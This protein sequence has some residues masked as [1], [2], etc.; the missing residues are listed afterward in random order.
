MSLAQ[1]QF[2]THDSFFSPPVPILPGAPTVGN[3][4]VAWWS[5]NAGSTLNT[6]DWTLIASAG[7]A[8]GG[9][10]I[11]YCMYR[12][13]QS[14]DGAT[15]PALSNGGNIYRVLAVEIS[16]VTGT[17]A[18]DFDQYAAEITYPPT[19]FNTSSANELVYFAFW[20]GDGGFSYTPGSGWT[21][22]YFDSHARIL[23]WEVIS[24]SGSSAADIGTWSATIGAML[25][26]AFKE[27]GGGDATGSGTLD[28][29]D[30]SAPT[31]VYV[32]NVEGSGDIA[33]ITFSVPTAI[34]PHGV[35]ATGSL[36]TFLVTGPT[37]TVE[38]LTQ[39]GLQVLAYGPSDTRLTQLGAS[40]LAAP[41]ANARVT[42][43]GLL[44][45]AKGG[46]AP[47]K[48]DPLVLHDAGRNQT[49]YQRMV[50]MYFEPTPQGPTTSAR[51]QRPGLY[52]VANRGG[53]PVQCT[54]LWNDFRITVSGGAVWRDSINIGNI[55]VVKG[56]VRFAFSEEEAVIVAGGLAYFVTTSKVTQ[57]TDPDMPTNLVDVVLLAGRFIYIQGTSGQFAY[58]QVGD[59]QNIDG[60]SFATVEENSGQTNVGAMVLVGSIVFFTERAMEFWYAADDPDNPFQRSPGRSTD[61]GLAAIRTLVR[62]DNAI[63]F[64]GENRIIYRAG[65]AVPQR[66]SDF[67]VEDK[68]R[69]VTQ[70]D[71][72]NCFAFEVIY[73]GHTFYVISLPGQGTWACDISQSNA[74]AEWR[75]H[76]HPLFRVSCSD[77]GVYGDL[78]SGQLMGMDGGLYTDPDEDPIERVVSSYLP[79]K[80][81]NTRNFNVGLFSARGVGLPTGYGSE[82]VVEMRFSDNEGKRWTNWME[83]PLGEIGDGTPNSLAVWT[84]LGAVRPP[85]RLYEFR[86]SDPV[87]FAPYQLQF[88]GVRMA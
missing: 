33:T 34:V 5:D 48:P 4:V 40:V 27:S 88:N 78:Y 12:Y 74:W 66:V 38:V 45:L 13:V 14:G 59:A 39:F 63:F 81:G 6:T 57:M 46:E 71:L 26:I 50:N 15:L 36:P 21:N 82:P 35:V 29:I 60:L 55:P 20:A 84:Q 25:T 8:S 19:A 18:N 22:D 65:G 69:R 28:E 42:Q 56:T 67:S 64:L 76:G 44:V 79:Q 41:N 51:Y 72:P 37:A 73:G 11:L 1:V 10:E 31:A 3:I 2:G 17:W 58:S 87:W 52:D 75:S 47:I 23:D 70:A 54:F 86:C 49:V 9:S 83:A 77:G 80:A 53:G 32:E 62:S 68:I 7:P 43:M 30:F 16:G 61:R 85:G 24:G